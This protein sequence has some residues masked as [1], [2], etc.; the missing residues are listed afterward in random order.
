V[1]ADAIRG[2]VSDGTAKR[3]KSAF[4]S[5]DGSIIPVGGKTGT[6]DQRFDVYAGG[7]A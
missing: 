3:V 5:H 6:G 7:G 2:V 4:V 1:V